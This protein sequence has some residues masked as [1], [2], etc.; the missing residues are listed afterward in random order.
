MNPK[1]VDDGCLYRAKGMRCDEF[2]ICWLSRPFHQVGGNPPQSLI[3]DVLVA[4]ELRPQA[5]VGTKHR[6]QGVK[7][8]CPDL[9]ARSGSLRLVGNF[10][11]VRESGGLGAARDSWRF[12]GMRIAVQT[13]NLVDLAS[14][15]CPRSAPSTNHFMITRNYNH[16]PESS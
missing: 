1:G 5:L 2:E 6:R 7:F 14:V 16:A 10:E 15:D 3:Q 12:K 8:A 13:A 4:V 9:N 11:F